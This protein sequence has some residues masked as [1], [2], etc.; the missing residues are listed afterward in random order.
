M[1]ISTL[2]KYDSRKMYK[3]YDKWPDI[4]RESF[5][6]E[7]NPLNLDN[8]KH[9]VFAGMGGS[10]TIGDIFSSV[11]SKS[12][13][14]VNVVKG[15]VLPETVNSDTLVI[16]TSVSGNTDETLS[17]L[18]SAHKLESNVITF[19]SGGKIQQYCVK[20]NIQNIIVT[21]YH[22]P[23]ASF[24]SYLYTMLKVLHTIFGI[25]QE[26]ILESILELEKISGKICSLNLTDNNPSI[27]LARGITCI[28]MIYYPFGLQ[29]VANRFKN[30]LQ[31]NSKIHVFTEDVIEACHNGIVA[32]ERKSDIQPVLIEGENDHIKTKERWKILKEYFQQNDIEYKEICSVKGS[33][34]TKII[35]LIYLTDYTTIY[36]AVLDKID[37]SPV[38]P[39]D[40]I[41]LRL[42]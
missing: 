31:E 7:Q 12:K 35:T 37:P 28:P 6:L 34:L 29:A 16:V 21:Q 19:S 36:K 42:K 2:E 1:D 26:D 8:I 30:S 32:W 41:K 23:R 5:E 20:N 13:I 40:F 3:I 9:V 11:L 24:T 38:I 10:G 17:I 22:S 39:I 27:N 14:H 33:I 4:A 15:Y 25:K 18:E